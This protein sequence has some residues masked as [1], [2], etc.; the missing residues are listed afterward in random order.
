MRNP[1]HFPKCFDPYLRYAISTRFKDFDFFNE[2]GGF[3]LFLLLEFKKSVQANDFVAE[4]NTALG[5]AA[6]DLGPTG[7]SSEFY[8]MHARIKA[9]T[10][11]HDVLTIWDRYVSRV[12]ISLPLKVTKKALFSSPTR[13]NEGKTKPG[14]ILIGVLDD[15]CPFAATQFLKNPSPVST[16]VRAIWDQNDREPVTLGSG[17]K[18]FEFG[19]KVPDFGYGLEF[20]RDYKD[21]RGAKLLGIDDWM[22]LHLTPAGSIDEDGCYRDAKFTRLAMRE[23]HGAHVMD[24]IAGPIPTSSRVS[25]L[26][27]CPGNVG[28][29]QPDPPSWLPGSDPASTAD[30]VFVQFPDRC[31]RDATGV[32]LKAYVLDGIRYILTFASPGTTETV[33][34][35]LSYGP[36]TGPHDGT[37]LLEKALGALVKEFNGKD[38]RPNLQIFLSAGNSYLTD[39]HVSFTRKMQT[40]RHVE[41]TWRLL[42]DNPV[43][44]FVEVW[45]DKAQARNVRVMLTSPSGVTTRSQGPL[46]WGENFVWLLDVGPTIVGGRTA[47]SEHGDYKIRLSGIGEDVC[48]HAY[49]A[50]TDPNMG[51]LSGAKPSYFVDP[52]WE[53]TRSAAASCTYADGEFDN[54]GSLVTRHGTLNGIATGKVAGVHVAGGVILKNGF[55]AAPYSSAGPARR[56]VRIGPDYGLFGDESYALQGVRAGGTRSGAVFRLIGTSAAA[57]Q[58]ARQIAKGSPPQKYDATQPG[59]QEKRGSADIKPP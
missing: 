26:K 50:R 53:D 22:R 19:Q 2:E 43:E 41:W 46:E 14:R 9:V 52:K 18:R 4:I 39:G 59:E 27:I 5:E 45:I 8:T 13:W 33:I 11:M 32:W 15:G 28:V 49:V 31:I 37:A 57:P 36:T 30:L 29:L 40:P 54:R 17:R 20:R 21:A 6:V 35:N 7:D 55:R 44:C 16:R 56:N 12:E 1:K 48:V 25:P 42:P 3:K 34:V 58:L 24:V 10:A 38:G 51:V 23:S 47:P